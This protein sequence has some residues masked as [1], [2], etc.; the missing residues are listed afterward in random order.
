MNFLHHGALGDII[1]SLPTI[2]AFGGGDFY[3]GKSSQFEVL[4]SLLELQPY[5]NSVNIYDKIVK[6]DA[7]LN[8]YRKEDLINK[9]L[10]RCHLDPFKK[11]Y[12]LSKSWL[13]GVEP[14]HVADIVICR[15]KRYHDKRE[16]DWSI[17]K[18]YEDRLVFVGKEEERDLLEREYGVNAKHYWCKD[19][20]E[21]AQ[22]IKGSKLYIGNQ[23]LGFSLAEAMK[24]PRVLE[25]YH[26]KNNCQPNSANGYTYLNES[27][28]DSHLID[29]PL[30]KNYFKKIELGKSNFK[31]YKIEKSKMISRINKHSGLSELKSIVRQDIYKVNTHKDGDIDFIIDIGANIGV[32]SMM[33][34]M[35]HPNAKIIAIEPNLESYEYLLFNINALDIDCEQKAFGNGQKFYYFDKDNA[36]TGNTYLHDVD[37]NDQK[38]CIESLT[39]KDIFE[40]YNLDMSQNYLLKFDCEGAE[41]YLI[42]DSES[43]KII[44][45]SLQTCLEIHFKS[46]T[47]QYDF[48]EEYGTYNDWINANFS[49]THFIDYYKSNKNKGYGHYCLTNKSKSNKRPAPKY[50]AKQGQDKWVIDTLNYKTNGYFIDIGAYNGID[51]SNSYVLEKNFDWKGICIEPN[52]HTFSEMKDHRNCICENICISDF[53]GTVEF[54]ERD[55]KHKMLS[56]IYAD[57]SDEAVMDGAKEGVPIVSRESMKLYDLLIKHDCPNIIEYLSIDTE[58]SE[59]EILK[60]FPFDKYIFKRITVEHNACNSIEN[61]EKKKKI[62]DLLTTN[63]YERVEEATYED[64]YVYRHSFKTVQFDDLQNLSDKYKSANKRIVSTNGVFD[65]LHPGHLRFLTECK[66]NGDV[67]VVGLNTDSSVK[68]IK[69][70]SRPILNQQERLEI[71]SHIDVIDHICLFEEETPCK[72]L[73]ILKPDIHCKDSNYPMDKIIEKQTVEDNGGKIK[74]IKNHDK[75]SA[76]NIIKKIEKQ[77]KDKLK[78]G[79]IVIATGRYLDLIKDP[80]F[81]LINSLHTHFFT[82]DILSIY[83]FTDGIPPENV[84]HIYQEQLPWPDPTLYRFRSFYESRDVYKDNDYIFY[85]DADSRVISDVGREILSDFTVVTHWSLGRYKRHGVIPVETNEESTAAITDQKYLEYYSGAFFGAKTEK[86]ISMSKE[87]SSNIDKDLENNI[88]AVWHDESHLNRY[89]YDNV[90]ALILDNRYQARVSRSHELENMELLKQREYKIIAVDLVKKNDYRFEG[91]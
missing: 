5:I 57:F 33:M 4:S 8:I 63:G 41:K 43:E 70:D 79:V 37:Q 80:R 1:Y 35:R 7:N 88:I 44:K 14:K 67:L 32:F 34:R 84:E 19:G 49:D 2:I 52:L 66:N 55:K 50:K 72:M 39:L 68:K 86:F 90:P 20:L 12:D 75:Y 47:T 83:L 46:K 54:V 87:L 82:E 45:N 30:I 18:K 56:G 58:G 36:L 89:C 9:H 21:I 74:L 23:S 16:I 6:I 17:L 65:I 38:E 76:T 22:I 71:L 3:F 13:S 24:H 11:E 91:K 27:L 60:N 73:D 51:E 26:G 69:G 85:I 53:N 64:W 29:S 77:S 31:N 61:K 15:T 62:F 81:D 48:F 42:G 40:I 25:V 78:I 28:I 10:C 59:Y